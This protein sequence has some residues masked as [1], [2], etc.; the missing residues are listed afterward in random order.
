MNI[1][2]HNLLHEL[3]DKLQLSEVLQMLMQMITRLNKKNINFSSFKKAF[4][5]FSFSFSSSCTS[6]SCCCYWS[7]SSS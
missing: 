7:S 1:I 4:S 2:G 6:C 3:V 5:S